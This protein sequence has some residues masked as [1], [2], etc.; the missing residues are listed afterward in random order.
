MIQAQPAAV[1]LPVR[2]W[3][4]GVAGCV[5]EAAE[6]DPAGGVLL[7][8]LQLARA[9]RLL[10]RLL[11]VVEVLVEPSAEQPGVAR[12]VE[13]EGG[14]ALQ[15]SSMI[16]VLTPARLPD[17]LHAAVLGGQKRALGCGHGT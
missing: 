11:D 4:G 8:V 2:F 7:D 14:D 1:A 3:P 12:A 17:E 16:V 5:V 15:R 9:G 10:G 13:E 6:H